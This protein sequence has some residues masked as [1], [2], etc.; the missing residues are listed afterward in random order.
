[1]PSRIAPDAMGDLGCEFFGC[2]ESLV[3]TLISL[4]DAG[5]THS[6][7]RAAAVLCTTREWG[8]AYCANAAGKF[9]Q[10]EDFVSSVAWSVGGRLKSVATRAA[11]PFRKGMIL[12]GHIELFR[13]F[14][15]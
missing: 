3:A 2:L 6:L 1:M 15:G 8:E 9:R 5:W 13:L 14:H 10:D 12:S 11:R 7:K 4:H